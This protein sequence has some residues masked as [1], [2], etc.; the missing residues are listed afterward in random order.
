MDE[1]LIKVPFINIIAHSLPTNGFILLQQ[2]FRRKKC[3]QI[4]H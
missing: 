2:F 3:Y 1:I 4:Q